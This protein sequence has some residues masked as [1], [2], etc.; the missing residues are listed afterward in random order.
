MISY[1]HP[2]P[3]PRSTVGMLYQ[4]SYFRMDTGT[5]FRSIIVSE[6]HDGYR[7]DFQR[8]KGLQK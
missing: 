5:L 6:R 1:G 8:T 2:D 3:G 7:D 4:M